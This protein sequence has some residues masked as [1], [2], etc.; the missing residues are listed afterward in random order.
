MAVATAVVLVTLI[1]AVMVVAVVA[2]VVLG[3]V[4]A[5]QVRRG[6]PRP[7]PTPPPAP[8]PVPGPQVAAHHPMFDNPGGEQ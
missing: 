6:A 3:G 4:K 7:A 1:G 2:L 5:L 8:A